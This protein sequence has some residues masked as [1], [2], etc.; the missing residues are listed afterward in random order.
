MREYIA[1]EDAKAFEDDN[2]YATKSE[3]QRLQ[4]E[5][6]K[7]AE[8]EEATKRAQK[9]KERTEAKAKREEENKKKALR[10]QRDDLCRN[11]GKYTTPCRA[12]MDEAIQK[13]ERN[14]L[15]E[16]EIREEFAI[17]ELYKRYF[18]RHHW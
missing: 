2:I 9:E 8:A 1:H 14:L 6:R 15:P 12:K 7:V 3:M 10:K 4:A 11:L 13:L 17:S 5:Q 16:T 18:K